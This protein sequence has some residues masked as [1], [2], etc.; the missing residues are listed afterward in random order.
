MKLTYKTFGEDYWNRDINC[1]LVGGTKEEKKFIKKLLS[2]ARR[3]D[4]KAYIKE[5]LEEIEVAA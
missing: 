4:K 1:P 3:A 2:K 5:A